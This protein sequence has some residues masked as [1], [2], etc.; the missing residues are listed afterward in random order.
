MCVRYTLHHAPVGWGGWCGVG[1]AV[2]MEVWRLHL[3]PA[4]VLGCF[5]RNSGHS[6]VLMMQRV[7]LFLVLVLVLVWRVA[8]ILFGPPPR[9]QFMHLHPT[10]PAAS[11]SLRADSHSSRTICSST[12]RSTVSCRSTPRFRQRNRCRCPRLRLLTPTSLRVSRTLQ[13][14]PAAARPSPARSG[15]SAEWHP[16]IAS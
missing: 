16:A 7:F 5:V 12:S 10:N 3:L 6:A 14:R 2:A 11:R 1:G 4:G 9:M 13:R 8:T 15:D